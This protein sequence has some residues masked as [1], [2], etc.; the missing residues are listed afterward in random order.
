MFHAAIINDSDKVNEEMSQY[1]G[2][3]V[4]PKVSQQ[5]V[6]NNFYQEQC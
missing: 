2:I 4:V 5:Q 1:K 3:Q 6:M